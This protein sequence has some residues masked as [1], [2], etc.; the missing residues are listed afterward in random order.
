MIHNMQHLYAYAAFTGEYNKEG[1]TLPSMPEPVLLLESANHDKS[2]QTTEPSAL[3]LWL[4]GI[5]LPVLCGFAVAC[6]VTVHATV[7]VAP[8]M[9]PRH[10]YHLIRVMMTL[11]MTLV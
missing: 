9:R 4:L 2:G 6:A 11:P 1:R 8:A 5:L 3:V 10:I 7:C